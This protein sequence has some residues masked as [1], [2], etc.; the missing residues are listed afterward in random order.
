MEA[1]A[2]EGV[3]LSAPVSEPEAGGQLESGLVYIEAGG[4]HGREVTT[5]R[6]QPP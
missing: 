5:K 2:I 4:S 1:G 3:H 6:D